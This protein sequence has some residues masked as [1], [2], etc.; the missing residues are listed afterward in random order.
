M[1]TYMHGQCCCL[2]LLLL[3]V[4]NAQ[5]NKHAIVCMDNVVV[6]CLFV[7]HLLFVCCLFVVV[8]N[9]CINK[10]MY[11]HTCIDNIVVVVVVCNSCT[12]KQSNP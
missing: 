2:C 7:V 4:I 9:S 12:N 1:I 5:I 3:S 10:R 6:C 11:K 8:C